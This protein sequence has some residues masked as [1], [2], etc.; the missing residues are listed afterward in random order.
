L[1]RYAGTVAETIYKTILSAGGAGKAVYALFDEKCTIKDFLKQLLQEKQQDIERDPTLKDKDRC[2]QSTVFY[3]LRPMYDHDDSW[4]L[5]YP[6]HIP[7]LTPEGG[8]K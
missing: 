3:R 2:T 8:K 6:P 7:P 1:E 4:P 5:P